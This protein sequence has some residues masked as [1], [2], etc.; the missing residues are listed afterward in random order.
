VSARP[1]IRETVKGWGAADLRRADVRRAAMI[2]A[3]MV[4]G[5][6]LVALTVHVLASGAVRRSLDLPFSGIP[7]R[8]SDVAEVFTNNLRLLGGLMAGAALGQLALRTKAGGMRILTFVCDAIVILA[9]ANEVYLVG[10]TVGAYGDRGLGALLP[11][12]PVEL[13]A[14]SLALSLYVAARRE[15]LE[16][17]RALTIAGLAVV[18]LAVAAVME[19]TA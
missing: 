4:A 8:L 18:V 1:L 19:V 10:A 12:G 7:H 16:F 13:S 2:A 15:C 11:H 5:A 17:A 14:Y 6:G 9:C 3:T